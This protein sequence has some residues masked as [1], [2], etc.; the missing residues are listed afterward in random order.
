[1]NNEI[2]LDI[3]EE[4][5]IELVREWRNKE[6]VKKNMY[7]SEEI[8]FSQQLQWFE[9]VKHDKVSKYWIIKK[10]DIAIGVANLKDIDLTNRVCSWA[11]YIGDETHLGGGVGSKVEYLVLEHVFSEL[12]LNKLKCEVFEFNESVIRLHEKFGFRR[13]GFLREEKIKNKVKYN[14]VALAITKKEWSFNKDSIYKMLY[15]N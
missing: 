5:S 9:K 2:T 11:F 12:K 15:R 1:M 14:V 8:S 13:E 3:L 10:G 7:N 6:H 4:E